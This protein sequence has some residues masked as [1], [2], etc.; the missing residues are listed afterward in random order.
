MRLSE[1]DPLEQHDFIQLDRL[2]QGMKFVEHTNFI[3]ATAKN[4]DI[5]AQLVRRLQEAMFV[6]FSEREQQKK[7]SR[8]EDLLELSKDTYEI[9][10]NRLHR[11]PKT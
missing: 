6:G 2:E 11:R 9:S 10:G 4:A 5:A 7:Q 3:Y 8:I 1:L